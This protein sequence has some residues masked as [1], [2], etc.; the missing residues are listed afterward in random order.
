MSVLKLS[1]EFLFLRS[2]GVSSQM[3]GS[4]YLTELEPYQTVF[5]LGM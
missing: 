1:N 3:T 5:T 4:Y 2:N